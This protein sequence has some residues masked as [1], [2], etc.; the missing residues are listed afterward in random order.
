MRSTSSSS[1]LRQLITANARELYRDGK[2]LFFVVFFPLLFLGMFLGFGHLNTGGS[3]RVAVVASPVQQQILERI[4]AE[5]GFSAEPWSG[6]AGPTQLGGYDAIVQATDG[7]AT[8]TLDSAKF[9]AMRTLREVLDDSGISPSRAAFR[10]PDGGQ[11]FDPVKAS[12]PTALVMA[13]MSVAFFGTATPLIA[14][15]Q[16]GTLRLL[17]TTPLR[18][19]TF[20]VAQA[21][22]RLALVA[23]QLI[24]LGAVAV[25]LGFLSATGTVLLFA[26]GMLGALML[27][28]FG[29]LAASRL[30]N[31][32]VANGLL[33]VLM[34][35]VLLLGG[36]FI[37][38]EMLPG[39][40]R[41]LSDA[42]P[43]TYL[44]DALN[45]QLTGAPSTHGLGVDWLVLTIATLIFGG[46]AACLFR[47]DQGEER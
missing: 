7:R 22:V 17:G 25:S 29:Y 4:A 32:E 28:A 21:P 9:G 27:F 5:D 35:L 45:H 40:L 19:L 1:A 42:L 24:L 20:V 30:R 33:A 37:P 2:T 46:L 8:V 36:L 38:L 34:P 26:T 43:T 41:T 18:R 14:L 15:R 23:G 47:W 39:A 12:L 31:P 11:P 10:T 16:R 13:L 3:Y 44:V 6:E